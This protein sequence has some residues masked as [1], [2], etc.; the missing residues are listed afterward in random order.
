MNL[1]PAAS[2]K[3]GFNREYLQMVRPPAPVNF[4]FSAE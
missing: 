2:G 4:L 3:S 1:D